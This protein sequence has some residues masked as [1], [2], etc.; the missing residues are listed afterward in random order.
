MVDFHLNYDGFLCLAIF[1]LSASPFL[2]L[3]SYALRDPRHLLC[4]KF[5][6]L[7]DIITAL[8]Q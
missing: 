3:L 5:E 8:L 6:Q 1:A 7:T 2:Y 4:P